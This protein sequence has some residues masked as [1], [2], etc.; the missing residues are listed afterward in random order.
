MLFSVVEC[1]NPQTTDAAESLMITE[2]F[3]ESVE[4]KQAIESSRIVRFSPG[5][6]EVGTY[7]A[8]QKQTVTP[9]KEE[10]SLAFY[11]GPNTRLGMD[12]SCS[13]VQN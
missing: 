11:L 6:S 9:K 2:N 4:L 13:S 10:T 8:I 12:A 5:F 3:W 7:P 1:T